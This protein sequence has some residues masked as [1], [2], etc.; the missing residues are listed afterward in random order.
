MLLLNY[1]GEAWTKI[2]KFVM[3]LSIGHYERWPQC[4]DLLRKSWKYVVE[5]PFVHLPLVGN[6]NYL[7]DRDIMFHY[8]GTFD[9]YGYIIH[10]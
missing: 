7:K 10:H 8:S 4:P 2:S 1:K 6:D 9:L 5:L 3:D